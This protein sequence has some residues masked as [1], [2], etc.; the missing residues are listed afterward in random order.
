MDQYKPRYDRSKVKVLK[1]SEVRNMDKRMTKMAPKEE[2]KWRPVSMRTLGYLAAKAKISLLQ[3]HHLI[4]DTGNK[5]F[6]DSF[7][8]NI[9]LLNP[10]D[11]EMVQVHTFSHLI[12]A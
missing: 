5:A 8:A 10:S 9:D 11:E 7:L 12:F 6:S 1:T 3:V 4:G 2:V